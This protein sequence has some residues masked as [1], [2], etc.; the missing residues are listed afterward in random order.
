MKTK[1]SEHL[2]LKPYCDLFPKVSLQKTTTYHHSHHPQIGSGN[3]YHGRYQRWN[4]RFK[5]T[6]S[7]NE[8]WNPRWGQYYTAKGPICSCDINND[9]IADLFI[10]G[11]GVG[12]VYVI[13]GTPNRIPDIDVTTLTYAEGFKIIGYA[14]SVLG[15]LR[16]SYLPSIY[17]LSTLI[18]ICL[19]LEFELFSIIYE[20]LLYKCRYMY[21]SMKFTNLE[22]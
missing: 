6:C 8:R 2:S 13:F 11:S 9:G 16:L 12:A 1:S 15:T 3:Q 21:L 10:H 17:N 19:L 22:L 14:N 4:T 18:N 7:H 20:C 5:P